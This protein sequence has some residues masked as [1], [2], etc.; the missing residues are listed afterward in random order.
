MQDRENYNKTH[1]LASAKKG[2]GQAYP[3]KIF[4]LAVFRADPHTVVTS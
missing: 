3:G 1:A 2:E 4:P